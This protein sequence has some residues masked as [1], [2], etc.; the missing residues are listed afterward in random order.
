MAF[1][2]VETAGINSTGSLNLNGPV[3][4]G[5]GTST[6]TESQTLQVTGGAYVSGNVGIG[7]TNPNYAIDVASADTTAG[8]GYALR[9]R[10]NA[11]AG[12]A[13]IQFTDNPVTTQYGYIACDSSSNLKFATGNFE[14]FR[15][16]SSGNIG[17][18]TTNPLAKV[19]IKYSDGSD[20]SGGALIL[21]DVNRN[22]V[23]YAAGS[24]STQ[25]SFYLRRGTPSSYTDHVIVSHN[26]NLTKPLQ[27]FCDTGT[28]SSYG[29]AQSLTSSP[30]AAKGNFSSTVTN[31]GNN[32]STSTDL[33]TC[34]E[35]GVYAVSCSCEGGNYNS[36]AGGRKIFVVSFNGNY[37]EIT[38]L[39]SI[40]ENQSP[41]ILRKLNT[42]D[43]IGLG[44]N[45]T[46]GADFTV[47]LQ[48]YFLG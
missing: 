19:H 11:T 24:T 30:A 44:I 39:N 26:G 15:V 8:I 43:T 14:R 47:R 33:Y 36:G 16:N 17:I 45:G 13:A 41:C 18:G 42:N 20:G 22:A 4:I 9:L 48:V 38:E 1:T 2:K 46:G 32:F 23:I 35:T 29:A 25:G 7:T 40:F 12:A 34:P 21:D 6:G 37:E 5:S 3:L 31:V 27:S 28:T 10:Q